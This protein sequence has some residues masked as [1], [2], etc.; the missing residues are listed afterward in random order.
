MPSACARRRLR[1]ERIDP[2]IDVQV[3]AMIV[4]P[5]ARLRPLLTFKA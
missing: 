2:V 4:A 1:Y 3:E 5:V